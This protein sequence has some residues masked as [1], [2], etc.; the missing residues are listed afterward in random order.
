MY[1]L[2]SQ[3]MNSP[4]ATV[5]LQSALKLV[6]ELKKHSNIQRQP[7]SASATQ[8]VQYVSENQS[9]DFLIVKPPDNPF[10]PKSS[11]SLF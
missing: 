9:K 1:K 11:C 4:A 3:K 8:L 6:D 7:V 10:K 2:V 5:Q